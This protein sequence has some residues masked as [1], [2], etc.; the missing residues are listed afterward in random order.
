MASTQKQRRYILFLYSQIQLS[1]H[2]DSLWKLIEHILKQPKELF[3]NE[4]K[5]KHILNLLSNKQAFKVIQGL[6]AIY[7]QNKKRGVNVVIKEISEFA[8][9][10]RYCSIGIYWG[11]ADMNARIPLEKTSDGYQYHD[12]KNLKQK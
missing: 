4:A 7:D 5:Q 11:V 12:C 10:C 1:S 8:N 9:K 3:W 2:Q 6:K